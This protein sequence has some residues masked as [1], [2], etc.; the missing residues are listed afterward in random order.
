MS[1]EE[2]HLPLFGPGPAYVMTIA[3]LTVAGIALSTLGFLPVASA[4]AAS[5][6][7]TVLGFAFMVGGVALWMTAVIGARIDRGIKSNRLVT[8]G[9]YAFVR[10]PVYSAFMFL[11]TGIVFAF[12]NLW[13]LVLPFVFWAVLTIFMK[14]TEEKWLSG[15]YGQDY[16]DYCKRVNRCIPWFPGG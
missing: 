15:L 4:G 16:A 12:G 9:I 5:V 10:N 3:L 13:L 1:K 8:D 14:A 7:L 2:S 11:C 6:V